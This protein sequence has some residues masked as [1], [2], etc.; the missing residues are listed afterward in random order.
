MQIFTEAQNDQKNGDYAAARDEIKKLQSL[1]D[2]NPDTVEGLMIPASIASFA[3]GLDLLENNSDAARSNFK[4][5]LHLQEAGKKFQEQERQ[6]AIAQSIDITL[7]SL[8]TVVVVPTQRVLSP[9]PLAI[10]DMSGED[11]IRMPVPNPP[12]I[13]Y[14]APIGRMT[15]TDRRQCSAPLVGSR[16]VVTAAHCV[17]NPDGSATA[18]GMTV[19]FGIDRT[20]KVVTVFTHQ[21]GAAWD[22]KPENDWALLVLDQ[23]TELGYFGVANVDPAKLS[24]MHFAAAG[25]SSDFGLGS[26]MT[27]DWKCPGVLVQSGIL[28]HKCAAWRG[29]S[30]GALL[31]ADQIVRDHGDHANLVGLLSFE[32][33]DK[34]SGGAVSSTA[35]LDK[36]L[37]LRVQY[38]DRNSLRLFGPAPIE[39]AVFT[40]LGPA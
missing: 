7:L 16:I 36:L 2:A 8:G 10:E 21:Y 28:M 31:D 22:R 17:T 24:E 38:G 14:L 15:T 9:G 4:S 19:S 6:R 33:A 25:Y 27:I 11:G 5:L 34:K 1:S 35:F 29:A 39:I 26:L 40:A 23:P 37:E 30:G 13:N 32:A 18:M 12:S 20:F 3:S